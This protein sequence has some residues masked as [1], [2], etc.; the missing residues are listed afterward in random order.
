MLESQLK[1]NA[2]A[3]QTDVGITF[4]ILGCAYMVS[5]PVVGYVSYT[6][7]CCNKNKTKQII[8]FDNNVGLFKFELEKV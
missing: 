5:S 2:N 4:V 1:D 6:T 8:L 3:S 7:I